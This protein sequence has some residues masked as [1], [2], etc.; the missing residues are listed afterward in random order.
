M[1][2]VGSKIARV[3]S[4]ARGPGLRRVWIRAVGAGNGLPA[5]RRWIRVSEVRSGLG[6]ASVLGATGD[7]G[8]G[9]RGI[10][11]VRAAVGSA[12]LGRIRVAAGDGVP[13][14][15]SARGK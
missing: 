10:K 15:G 11:L 12:V 2:A 7:T 13:G 1:T 3:G 4:G 9:C 6:V 14:W 5:M 8:A